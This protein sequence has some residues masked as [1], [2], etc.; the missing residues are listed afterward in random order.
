MRHVPICGAA[1][2]AQIRPR[3]NLAVPAGE[4]FDATSETTGSFT[5]RVAAV[6][7]PRP[8]KHADHLFLCAA[9][10]STLLVNDSEPTSCGGARS[11]VGARFDVIPEAREAF[12]PRRPEASEPAGARS[13]RAATAVRCAAAAAACAGWGARARAYAVRRV[14]L[15]FLSF[16]QSPRKQR[17]TPVRYLRA[18]AS[19]VLCSHAIRGVPDAAPR[20]ARGLLRAARFGDRGGEQVHG[21]RGRGARCLHHARARVDMGV[22]NGAVPTRR[23]G[24]DACVCLSLWFWHSSTT[25]RA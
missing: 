2:L 17:G 14:T 9:L 7:I 20:H 19:V 24:H 22:C 10:R 16:Q 11:P 1:G 6:E 18:S 5:S 23:G 3:H 15:S 12:S 21:A 8:V 25:S 4:L 13:P